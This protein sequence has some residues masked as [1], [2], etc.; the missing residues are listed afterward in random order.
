MSPEDRQRLL[1][2]EAARR[3]TASRLVSQQDRDPVAVARAKRIAEKFGVGT[4]LVEDDPKPFEAQERQQQT[5]AALSEYPWMAPILSD[6]PDTAAMLGKDDLPKIGTLSKALGMAPTAAAPT[7][8]A[9]DYGP[10]FPD[11]SKVK[12]PKAAPK[13]VAWTAKDYATRLPTA[14]LGAFGEAAINT[15]QGVL[16]GLEA[17][18]DI[19]GLNEETNAYF[20]QQEAIGKASL[21]NMRPE[22][23]GLDETL[24]AGF[25]PA[26][27]IQSG[28]SSAMQMILSLPI[29]K[30]AILPV[31][32]GTTAGVAY[33][34]YQGRGAGVVPSLLGATAEGA[35]EY[36]TEKIP[37]GFL[38]SG[39]K[40]GLTRFLTHYVGGELVGEQLATLGQD[41]VE[42]LVAPEKPEHSWADFWKERPAAALSTLYAT[43]T[44]T[45]LVGGGG[46]V[47]QHFTKT[48]DD[49]RDSVNAMHG[50][51][52]LDEVMKHAEGV[53][54]RKNAP[55]EFAKFINE[56]AK[57]SPVK[58]VY[59]PVS[60]VDAVLESDAIPDEEKAALTLYQSQI[61]EARVNDGEIVI[62]IGEAAAHLAG[63]KA[64]ETLRED[65]RV[66]AGGISG[67]EAKE[68]MER[69]VDELEAVGNEA[70][71]EASKLKPEIEAKA[72][73]YDEVKAQVLAAGRSPREAQT[74]AVL[75]AS[76]AENLASARYGKFKDAKAAYDWMKLQIQGPDATQAKGGQKVAQSSVVNI[77][78]DVNDGSKLTVPEV[79]KVLKAQG[80]KITEQE[81]RQSGTEPTLVAKLSKPLTPEQAHAVS[82]ALRQ[83][84]I[85]Q[86]IGNVGQ[87]HGPAAEKWGPFNPEYFLDLSSQTLQQDFLTPLDQIASAVGALELATSRKFDT[88]RDFKVQL[89]AAVKAATPGKRHDRARLTRLALADA[90]LALQQNQNAIGWYDEKLQQAMA[91]LGEL[92]PEINT[93]E[94]A[95]FAF[96]YALAVTSTGL[97]VDRNFRIADIAY[98]EYKKTGQMPMVG[99]GNG[100]NAMKVAFKHFNRLVEERGIDGLRTIMTTEHS[101]GELEKLVGVPVTGEHKSTKVTGAAF[102]GPK[103]GNGYFSNLYGDYSRL[104]MDRWF[105]RTWGRWTGSL[106]TAAP[107]RVKKARA[108]TLALMRGLSA[109]QRKQVDKLLST[110][111]NPFK[112]NLRD[113]EGFARQVTLRTN[114]AEVRA[115]LEAITP[116]LRSAPKNLYIAID[117]Q[118]E[119]P[120][121]ATERNEIRSVFNV[122]LL[123]LQNDNPELTMAD[124]Q[125]VLWY[126]E[127]RLYDTAKEDQ[128]K[129][130]QLD[131][132]G[133]KTKQ[134]SQLGYENDDAPDYANAA[135]A[136]ARA[137]GVAKEKIDA[138]VERGR[139][140]AL[141]AQRA[142]RAGRGAGAEPIQIRVEEDE[143]G[144]PLEDVFI[145][146]GDGTTD[147]M[148]LHQFG[149]ASAV[150]DASAKTARYDAVR[151][152][153]DGRSPESIWSL[154]G[155][156]RGGDGLW[157]FE[158]D[159]SE[160]YFSHE[161]SMEKADRNDVTPGVDYEYSQPTMGASD[162]NGA[163]IYIGERL[164]NILH[165]P[166]LFKHYPQLKGMGVFK[167]DLPERHAGYF[168]GVNI[169]LN[170]NENI[171]KN[172]STLLHEVQHAIQTI[173][174]FANGAAPAV[175]ALLELGLGDQYMQYLDYYQAVNRGEIPHWR[176]DKP[177]TEEELQASAAYAVYER[178]AGE[179]EAR[180]TQA[181]SNFG[182]AERREK[183][184]DITA[185][186]ERDNVLLP[187]PR[188]QLA[189]ASTAP[190]EGPKP[191]RGEATFYPDGRT[192][193]QLFKADFSTMLHEMSHVFLV[194]EFRLAKE[195]GASEELKADV[196]RLE[197]WFA[198]HGH[199][200]VDGKIPVEAH[201]LFARTGERYFREG[202]APSAELRSAFKQFK[203]WLSG[204]YKSV[205]DLL[206]YGP[207]P[208][209][210]E[211][212]DIM[213]RMVATSDAIEA[214]AIAPMSQEELGMTAAEY[215]AYL[216]SVNS[217]KD[218]AHDAL[219]GRMMQAIR[220]RE[221]K[222]G[223]AQRADIRAEVEQEVNA[224]P[225]FVA[226]HLLRTGRWL[227]QPE[228][229]RTDVK[230]DTGWLIDN[231]GEEVLA[232]LPVG[233]Q[234]LHRGDGVAGDVVAE[235]VDMRSGDELVRA[236]IELK[237]QAD[238]LK[239]TGN[240]RPLRDQIIEDR[241]NALMAERH[242]DMAM[243]EA[244]IEE[245]A[246]AALN[247]NRQGEVLATEL[248]QLK[249][250][251]DGG[252]VT[253]YQLL[254][255]WARRK[256]N[257]GTVGDAV[258]K[259]A[260][261]RYVRAFNK[262]RSLFEDAI[263][264]G[265]AD[266]A[267]KQKQA[268]MI[269]HALLAEGK[270][271]AD[272]IG[273]I[274]RR[275]QR[276]AKTK[277][278]AS[279]DQD[280]MD[281][282]HE[283][284]EGYNFRPVSDRA[285]QEQ[286]SF[287]V[288]A[289]GQRA[290]GHEVYV[291]ARF[292]DKRT[293]WKDAQVA[294]LIELND[295][296]QSLAAQGKLKQ[297]L[298]IAGEERALD[299]MRDELEAS[300]LSLPERGLA[301]T[302]TGETRK[303][304]RQAIREAKTFA[305]YRAA[306]AELFSP[307]KRVRQFA[308][309]LVKIEGVADILDANKMG[310]GVLNRVLIQGAT[311][312]VN[313]FTTLTEEVMEPI[314]KLY[315]G[316]S[317]KLA[318]RLNDLVTI[319]E[320]T[321]NAG[322]H[323]EDPRVGQPLNITRKQ[324]LAL[325]ANTGNLSNLAKLVGGER[326]GD[327]ESAAD[328]TRVQQTL[329]GY[330]NKEEMDLVQAMWDGIA[331][332]W[333]H[334]VRVER[335]LT[336]IVPEAVVPMDVET[337]WGTYSGGY[338]PV[339]WDSQRTDVGKP[340]D[341]HAESNLFG[342]GSNLGT[343]KGH[344]ITRTGAVA[345][346]DWSLEGVLFGHTTKVI[347]R[348]AYAPW[349]RDSLKLLNSTRVSG[350]IR[351]RLG[352]EYLGAIKHWMK[353]QIPS[354][355]VDVAG[356][357]FYEN[358][359]NQIRINF[360][361]GVLG[362]SWSTGVAQALG[363]SY[364]AGVLGEGSVKDGGKW[365]AKGFAKMIQLQMPGQPG[366]QEFVFTRS[367]EMRRRATELNRE[368]I[369]VFKNLK[370]GQRGRA[371][372]AMDWLQAKAFW[373]IAFIDLNAVSVPTWLA[374]YEKAKA[375]GLSE[376]E[377][378]AYGDKTVRLSQG[379]GR[380][381]DMSAIQRGTAGQ[382]FV[383]MFYTP[384]SVF[385]NQQWEAAQHFKAGNWSK[386][387]AP[388]FWFLLVTT[389]LDAMREGDWPDDDDDDG[390]WLDSL[391]GWIGRNLLFGA[392][393]GVPI[394]RDVANTAER[395]LRGQYATW[396]QTPLSSVADAIAKGGSSAFKATTTDEPVEAKDVKQMA[397]AV[398]FT[399][400]IPANQPG[401]TGGF[402][403]N[404]E[405]G[406]AQPEDIGDWFT[407]LTTGKLPEDEEN[408]Q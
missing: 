322:L 263:L 363:L 245:E 374:G 377:A 100:A 329:I 34:K 407:G 63:T 338:W 209:N 81:V 21:K 331:K 103:I 74:T 116:R 278:M 321:L 115:G 260:L 180:N 396:G 372:R 361:I 20:R 54:M 40:G 226:L 170:G 325:V 199:P 405:N 357:K 275:M 15:A 32:A 218:S 252:V 195:K 140:R 287:E 313:T 65:A 392:F 52:I 132:F 292:R 249:K 166:Q 369:D 305:E 334:I 248:R 254:R 358:V 82:A 349:V 296:V 124:L 211:I 101:A 105:M 14:I 270:K 13:R 391:P 60:A 149:G 220:R 148:V 354:N 77:G 198:D 200:V 388:T 222:R 133:S 219:L 146:A 297:R 277:A 137:E 311:D 61:E 167:I 141:A 93:D 107:D 142:R 66:L 228:R 221:E 306:L 88:I 197:K 256:V 122:V 196:A 128:G 50:Q 386:G 257:E 300:I 312:A 91:V 11:V 235:M 281:R 102:L 183:F 201:E 352:N 335:E 371:S 225:R 350:A 159:D 119:A 51:A 194:Q 378:A 187:S 360:T 118:K 39:L 207:A 340:S 67:R 80:V 185:D 157:R 70:F 216:D 25:I 139:A 294:K 268:Q 323:A 239:A 108:E 175:D 227:G 326:W 56:G 402:L 224:D 71:T 404:V 382:R 301:D 16:G 308:S 344:T 362:V 370:S 314:T 316:M 3:S 393:Y 408:K 247:S 94:D 111:G 36:G 110:K 303:P 58:N 154:T 318:A 243:T 117:G 232:R 158:I 85:A 345:P 229:E 152:E 253:P 97:K 295:M 28:V 399:L 397:M 193:I 131:L 2:E 7:F 233:L 359:L 302:S 38:T 290:L 6:S 135:V 283:L 17:G 41:A 78:L 75:L 250:Q 376:E 172:L 240:P 336:G 298:T 238:E 10:M 145:S 310:L 151:M 373:H 332:L 355:M 9:P 144:F 237:E 261:Q 106:I 320:L 351:L 138:A 95:R 86:R 251:K 92:H 231:Y 215:A 27:D 343:P 214:N 400:G 390:T 394:V 189:A 213:S 129:A 327:P 192:I 29:G 64:W 12:P 43:L 289:E 258:S 279:I 383:A 24:L 23:L 307:R 244:E 299:E 5:D 162:E 293:N 389:L 4:Q 356:A 76:R 202:K 274:I 68:H 255:E 35:I 30:A 379:S 288:W 136:L 104:T 385:F 113:P 98:R 272:E 121:N 69:L 177:R 328:L 72:A 59:I 99:E 309:G 87:L 163:L 267:I 276:Y 246:I 96:I 22:W 342:V 264:G 282:I 130:V 188:R 181:R 125:A 123:E 73:V 398:G 83:D 190:P 161:L 169:V 126:P 223:R 114:K 353:D 57:D 174:G 84:A 375:Q 191:V 143:A 127:K 380:E 8:A 44:T 109:A 319:P 134:E 317:G 347:S 280:Y 291:P 348:I 387:L 206:A 230:I 186:F 208:I 367:E 403:M 171:Q 31:L 19:V 156:M 273:T 79:V 182:R 315:R 364:S 184:P 285:R 395:K 46:K 1:D 271:V 366:A 90:R 164:G 236:L 381:K 89:Q 168:D 217:A 26:G 42:Q 406:N 401:K 18:A 53:E 45:A 339:V 160:A 155:W 173:E 212:R 341:E 179:V 262:A 234:P 265:K 33:T 203:E 120:A 55:E 286:A 205:Q 346:M 176:F 165:H 178:V 324:L 49:T 333:P 330:L 242:G 47:M 269:N 37:V 153:R 368:V 365:M 150:L 112:M 284:L 210:P 62:P 204:V 147:P 266:E 48:V 337:P 241:T 384:S 304:L 259:A